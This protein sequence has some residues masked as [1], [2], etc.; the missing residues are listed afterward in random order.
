MFQSGSLW[1]AYFVCLKNFSFITSK[2]LIPIVGESCLVP[3][4]RIFVITSHCYSTIRPKALLY[5]I[6][7]KSW[8]MD[9][10]DESGYI[11][12]IFFQLYIYL[13]VN[14]E[15]RCINLIRGLIGTVYGFPFF[16]LDFWKKRLL[17]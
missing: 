4:M 13:L 7:M 8:M 5:L 12:C 6:W 16:F 15:M 9:E 1:P 11:T 14:K 10:V 3:I 2:L 17:I